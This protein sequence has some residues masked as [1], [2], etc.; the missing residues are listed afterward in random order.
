MSRKIGWGVWRLLAGGALIV[1][2][3]LGTSALVA[4]VNRSHTVVLAAGDL[5]VGH[6]L[7]ARDLD[8]G[9]GFLAGTNLSTFASVSDAVGL[10][11]TR[12]VARG[13]LVSDAVVATRGDE[14]ITVLVIALAAPV[15]ETLAPGDTVEIWSTGAR[16]D[17][18]GAVTEIP[19]EPR[20][21][22]AG[23]YVGPGA[24]DGMISAGVTRAEV[25]LAKD[26][27]EAVLA[28]GTNN[29]GIIVV[30]AWTSK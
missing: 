11:T 10:V 20:A 12:P 9:E 28:A 30:P 24:G 1:A 13:E 15:P 14:R 18:A 7:T 21:L 27:V 29:E 3:V 19:A 17:V 4:S 22:A 8:T 6:V 25:V 26:D 23:E 5:P 2:S 16:V